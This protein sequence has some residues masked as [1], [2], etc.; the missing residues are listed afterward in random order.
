MFILTFGISNVLKYRDK[1]GIEIEKPCFVQFIHW[2]IIDFIIIYHACCCH[3]FA[4]FNSFSIH[5]YRRS[6]EYVTASELFWWNSDLVGY[7]HHIAQCHSGNWMDWHY[8]A[9]IHYA[10]HFIFIRHSIAW[11]IIRWKVQTV[12]IMFEFIDLISWKTKAKNFGELHPHCCLFV[13]K[14]SDWLHFSSF[15]LYTIPTHVNKQ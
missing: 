4:L 14:L 9:I 11:K 5:T 2:L 13:T 15:L 10:N 6:M 12:R 7:F 3:S 8:I 1:K